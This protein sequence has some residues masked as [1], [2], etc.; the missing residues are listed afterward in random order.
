MKKEKVFEMTPEQ[1]E[2]SIRHSKNNIVRSVILMKRADNTLTFANR[3]V[4]DIEVIAMTNDIWNAKR[5]IAD[6]IRVLEKYLE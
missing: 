2:T 1:I 3:S 4:E 6:A 5:G